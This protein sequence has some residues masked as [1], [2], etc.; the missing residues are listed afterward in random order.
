MLGDV[1]GRMP[2]RVVPAR[3]VAAAAG[4]HPRPP[5]PAVQPD[6]ESW[7]AAAYAQT[8]RGVVALIASDRDAAAITDQIG[9][10][11][12]VT[13]DWIRE[14]IEANGWEEDLLATMREEARAEDLPG[15]AGNGDTPALSF[16]DLLGEDGAAWLG[17]LE[18][19]LRK[20]NKLILGFDE[21]GEL[22]ADQFAKIALADWEK[23]GADLAPETWGTL[24]PANAGIG[25]R[26][27]PLVRLV[28]LAAKAAGFPLGEVAVIS[29]P[30]SESPMVAIAPGHR[31]TISPDQLAK[32]TPLDAFTTAF[33]GALDAATHGMGTSGAAIM[34]AA[35]K[36]AAGIERGM[37]TPEPG[38]GLAV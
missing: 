9:R 8:H 2:V 21:A 34:L 16:E 4:D 22:T 10:F 33:A 23:V 5:R 15:W 14:R 25:E 30:G 26:I 12:H 27:L 18:A 19:D 6:G 35:G 11:P 37:R 17:S 1:V 28:D 24:G 31:A 32:A 3:D 36:A 38:T 20:G 13:A 29:E 7:L